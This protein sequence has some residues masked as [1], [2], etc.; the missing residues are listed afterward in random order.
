MEWQYPRWTSSLREL[1]A[2]GRKE[3]VKKAEPGGAQ[4]AVRTTLESASGGR[5]G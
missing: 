5:L 4:D 1:R 3:S 2:G